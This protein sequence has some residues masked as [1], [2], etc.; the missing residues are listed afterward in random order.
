MGFFNGSWQGMNN[1]GSRKLRP[2][3]LGFRLTFWTRFSGRPWSAA[4][5]RMSRTRGS[6]FPDLLLYM[7]LRKSLLSPVQ[8]R[9]S[10]TRSSGVPTH[11]VLTRCRACRL[12]I[13]RAQQYAMLYVLPAKRLQRRFPI[14]RDALPSSL[15]HAEASPRVPW[16]GV[17]TTAPPARL[18]LGSG[19]AGL[20]NMR[21]KVRAFHCASELIENE[22]L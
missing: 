17:L 21:A 19:C 12:A 6:A 4:G 14:G 5:P 11:Q 13:E 3:R 10:G 2:A 15:R 16:T 1:P 9:M 22:V 7:S 20:V 18:C 8:L